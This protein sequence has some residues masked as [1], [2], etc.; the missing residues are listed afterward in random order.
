[1]GRALA[2]TLLALSAPNAS[3]FSV[4]LSRRRAI[5]AAAAG[6]A[7]AVVPGIVSTKPA[8]AEVSEETPRVVTR[9]GGLLVRQNFKITF[10]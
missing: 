5:Q 9:M 2:I 3:A 4:D 8:N 6:V 7:S 1:M 10:D